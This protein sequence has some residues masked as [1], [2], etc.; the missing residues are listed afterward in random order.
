MKLTEPRSE[1]N[2]KIVAELKNGEE[3]TKLCEK[4]KVSKT[5]IEQLKIR[6]VD[7]PTELPRDGRKYLALQDLKYSGL[8]VK[9]IAKKY[10]MGETTVNLLKS[11]YIR[12][13]LWNEIPYPGIQGTGGGYPNGRTQGAGEIVLSKTWQKTANCSGCGRTGSVRINIQ[14]GQCGIG[15]SLCKCCLVLIDKEVIEGLE[16]FG[17][18]TIASPVF[19]EDAT[20]ELKCDSLDSAAENDEAE[21]AEETLTLNM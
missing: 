18:K 12:T 3:I 4:Y 5:N 19:S 2:R 20:E 11:L 14:N 15:I 13:D 1:I 17:E 7:I 10:K 6:Y 16:N 21:D 9:E 8:M